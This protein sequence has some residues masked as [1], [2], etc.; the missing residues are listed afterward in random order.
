LEEILTPFPTVKRWEGLTQ[1]NGHL[2]GNGIEEEKE[3]N[4]Q[5]VVNLMGPFLK[6][7]TSIARETLYQSPDDNALSKGYMRNEVYPFSIR[8]NFNNGYK[9]ALFPLI[10]RP[11]KYFEF[12]E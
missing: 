4:L 12:P 10:N 9:T 8:F 1:T 5:P 2:I 3:I 6:W 7:Q 11:A